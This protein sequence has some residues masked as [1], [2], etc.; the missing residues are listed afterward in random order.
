MKTGAVA[1]FAPA[2]FVLLPL[3]LL[4]RIMGDSAR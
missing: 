1:W 2:A 3:V 4:L